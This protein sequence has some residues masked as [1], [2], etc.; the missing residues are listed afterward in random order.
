MRSMLV[1]DHVPPSMYRRSLIV[2][3]WYQPG[4]AHDAMT[5]SGAPATGAPGRPNGT[6]TPRS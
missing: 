3:G 4:I 1:D 5:A 2:T 6:R